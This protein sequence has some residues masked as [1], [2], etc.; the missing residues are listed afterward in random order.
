MYN[1]FNRSST[2][3]ISCVGWV[4]MTEKPFS[5]KSYKMSTNKAY[6]WK[7]KDPAIHKPVHTSIHME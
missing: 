2:N 6:S 1:V 7:R 4:L 5:M 3:A